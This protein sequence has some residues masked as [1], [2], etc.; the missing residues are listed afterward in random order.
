MPAHG[1]YRGAFEILNLSGIIWN[2]CLLRL[3]VVSRFLNLIQLNL[4]IVSTLN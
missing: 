1:D 3:I 2:W 4:V